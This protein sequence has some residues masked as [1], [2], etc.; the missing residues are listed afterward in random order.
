MCHFKQKKLLNTTLYS[1]SFKWPFRGD[2]TI[3][4]L[5]QTGHNERHFTRILNVTGDDNLGNRVILGDRSV[6]LD[7]TGSFLIQGYVHIT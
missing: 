2:I 6:W 7:I 3:K 1:P 4:I 5:N